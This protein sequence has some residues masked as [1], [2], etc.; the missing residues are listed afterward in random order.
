MEIEKF[1]NQED[2]EKII[3][4]LKNPEEVELFLKSLEELVSEG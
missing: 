1:L 3:S 4:E 2:V